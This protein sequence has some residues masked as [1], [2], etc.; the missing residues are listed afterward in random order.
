MAVNSLQAQ[1]QPEVTL[2]HESLTH[3]KLNSV[4]EIQDKLSNINSLIIETIQELGLATIFMEEL[5][6][7]SWEEFKQSIKDQKSNEWGAKKTEGYLKN[8]GK[9]DYQAFLNLKKTIAKDEPKALAFIKEVYIKEF[10]LQPLRVITAANLEN[11]QLIEF[12][13]KDPY[14]IDISNHKFFVATD[15]FRLNKTD[16]FTSNASAVFL[17][18]KRRL[19]SLGKGLSVPV[20]LSNGDTFELNILSQKL[21]VSLSKGILKISKEVYGENQFIVLTSGLLKRKDIKV[22]GVMVQEVQHFYDNLVNPKYS[23]Y[24]WIEKERLEL[25]DIFES[26][27]LPSLEKYIAKVKETNAYLT[28]KKQ[29]EKVFIEELVKRNAG[30]LTE[31]DVRNNL[32]EGQVAKAADNAY[33]EKLVTNSRKLVQYL[34]SEIETLGHTAEIRFFVDAGLS[35]EE[36]MSLMKIKF[37]SPNKYKFDYPFLG[38]DDIYPVQKKFI[39]DIIY[40]INLE[41]QN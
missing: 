38:P 21:M 5:H 32:P 18:Y 17:N 14:R 24:K 4:A 1:E 31:E 27:W 34:Y 26:K 9:K 10:S 11:P 23:D 30:R 29:F 25:S 15:F 41:K 22:A 12:F 36:I 19:S 2:N 7:Y 40:K 3:N 13:K 33:R 16:N 35:Q 28:Y 37:S 20:T 6:S 39:A 8:E